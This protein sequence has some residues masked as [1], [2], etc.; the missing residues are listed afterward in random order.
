MFLPLLSL[1]RLL[2]AVML[3]SGTWNL[4]TY[5]KSLDR[6]H[7]RELL[8]KV[9]RFYHDSCWRAVARSTRSLGS[10]TEVLAEMKN[11]EQSTNLRDQAIAK[12]D[13]LFEHFD[14]R[15][16]R[17]KR[18]YERYTYLTLGL[19]AAITVISALQALYKPVT[20]WVWVLPVV[21]GLATFCASM[22][23]ATNAH[24]L[25]L[26]A[27]TMTQKLETERFLFTQRAGVYAEGDERATVE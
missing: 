23:H 12:C 24:Q 10:S 13:D 22:V 26:R 9:I 14:T 3:S 6:S 16:H 19:T 18:R 20:W 7:R 15:A 4:L 2:P 11:F 1:S 27:R 8:I 17:Y 25:W 5:N 21:S